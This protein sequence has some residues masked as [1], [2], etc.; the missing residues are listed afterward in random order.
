VSEG[1]TSK[2][3]ALAITTMVRVLFASKPNANPAE[4]GS[5]SALSGE[6]GEEQRPCGLKPER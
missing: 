1:P 6:A 5:A 4:K 3:H 2:A